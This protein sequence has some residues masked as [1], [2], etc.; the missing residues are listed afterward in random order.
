MLIAAALVIAGLLCLMAGAEWVI[1]GAKAICLRFRVSELVIG[2]I[3]VAFGTSV[4]ELAINLTGSFQG[5]GELC[6]GNIVGSNIANIGLIIGVAALIRPLSI[7]SIVVTR[8][9]P[10]LL[11]ASTV[12]VALGFDCFFSGD[13]VNLF[14]RG[15]A[16]VLLL[17]FVT[18]LYYTLMDVVNGKH[19]P[20]IEVGADESGQGMPAST[21]KAISLVIVGL[22]LL[23]A[24]GNLTVTGAVD[25][26]RMIGISDALIGL[27]IVAVGTSLPELVTSIIAV[28][29]GKVHMAVG[30]VV[31]SNVFN[32]MFVLGISSLVHPVPIPQGEAAALVVMLL[33]T[34]CLLPLGFS[35]RRKIVRWEGAALIIFYFGYFSWQTLKNFA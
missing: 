21:V 11:L 14:S 31:G 34:L 32:L 22:I 24:G 5:Q 8:E 7:A 4:P 6:Y 29:Y 9:I 33:L 15:D 28:R 25:L 30:N 2:L 1:R 19:G 12:A 13:P 3:V 27:T 18:F 10:M 26:A 23:A 17:L 20:S 35:D 16:A